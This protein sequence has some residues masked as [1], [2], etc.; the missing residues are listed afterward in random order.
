MKSSTQSDRVPTLLVIG[1]LGAGKSTILN[2]LNSQSNRMGRVEFQAS[3][4]LKGL[5][6]D[7]TSDVMP[8]P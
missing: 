6:K 2:I 1:A 8:F 3:N 7:F 5:T 4:L